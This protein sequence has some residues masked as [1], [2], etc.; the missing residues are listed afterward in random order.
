MVNLLQTLW[1]KNKTNADLVE[2]LLQ[3][4]VQDGV[5]IVKATAMKCKQCLVAT[6]NF[7]PP[8]FTGATRVPYELEDQ[9]WCWCC[10]LTMYILHYCVKLHIKQLPY[11]LPMKQ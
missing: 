3:T 9:V 2:M 10:H 6:G 1:F 7:L 11:N 8:H 5:E 4:I